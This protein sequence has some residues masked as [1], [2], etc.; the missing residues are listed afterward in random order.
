MDFELP[1]NDADAIE[2]TTKLAEK[3]Y[4]EIRET[5]GKLKQKMRDWE[6]LIEELVGDEKEQ[7]QVLLR[8]WCTEGAHEGDDMGLDKICTQA[9]S[10][11]TMLKSNVR[12]MRTRLES[13]TAD[14]QALAPRMPSREQ[15]NG[16]TEEELGFSH[17]VSADI[18]MGKLLKE[19]EQ[20]QKRVL[21]QLNSRTKQP[22]ESHPITSPS[23]NEEGRMKGGK[24]QGKLPP[25]VLPTFDGDPRQWIAFTQAFNSI[26]DTREIGDEGKF[27]Y[28]RGAL[29]GAALR[30]I[31]GLPGT[32]D[33]YRVAWELLR[34]RFG[35][36]VKRRDKLQID[37]DSLRRCPESASLDQLRRQL[38]RMDGIMRQL[39]VMGENINTPEIAGVFR[40]VFPLY[41]VEEVAKLMS[42]KREWS[43]KD[44]RNAIFSIL[45]AKEYAIEGAKAQAIIAAAITASV[46]KGSPMRRNETVKKMDQKKQKTCRLCRDSHYASMCP[47]YPNEIRKKERAKE[48][49]LCLRC[50]GSH[51]TEDCKRKLR[52]FFCK[53]DHIAAFCPNKEGRK[54]VELNLTTVT[55]V[56]TM[57]IPVTP[58]VGEE[59]VLLPVKDAIVTREVQG[60]PELTANIFLDGGAQASFITEAFARRLNATPVESLTLSISTVTQWGE[61]IT[62]PRYLLRIRR[63]DGSWT[64]VDVLGLEDL[65]KMLRAPVNVATGPTVATR[66]TEV[67]MLIG[68]D[69]YYKIVENPNVHESGFHIIKSAIGDILHGTGNV[70]TVAATQV[71]TQEQELNRLLEREWSLEGIGIH[72]D[73]LEK[74]DD[75]AI[76]QFQRSIQLMEGRYWARLPKKG[77]IS[78]LKDNYTLAL[79][80]LR[81]VLR[82]LQEKDP[83]SL[84]EYARIIAEQEEMGI[85][86]RVK[87]TSGEVVHYI[88]HHM[89]HGKKKRIVYDASAKTRKGDM[90]LNDLLLRG[91]LLLADLTGILLRFRACEIAT[92]ADIAKAFLMIALF[93]EDRDLL[94]FLFVKNIS[95]PPEGDNLIVYRFARLPF[96]LICAPFILNA[97][98]RHHLISYPDTIAAE[99]ADNVY[100]D[101]VVLNASSTIEAQEKCKEA[102]EIFKGAG[103]ELREFLSSDQEVNAGFADKGQ[104]L[105]TKFLGL[106]WNT[107]DDTLTIKSKD[108]NPAAWTKREVA[109]V[110]GEAYDPA[111]YISP[112]LLEAKRFRQKI[113]NLY[114]WSDKLS[115]DYLQEW[116]AI[117]TKIANKSFVIPRR[118]TTLPVSHVSELHVFCDASKI[119]YGTAVYAICIEGQTRTSALVFARSRIVPED[120]GKG[121]ITIPRLELT[122][123]T[124]GLSHLRF[125]AQELKVDLQNCTIWTDS[126]CVI[127]WIQSSRGEVLPKFVSNRILELHDAGIEIRHVGTEQNPADI[128]S[129]GSTFEELQDN[130]LW[131]KGP[132][133]LCLSE[134]NWPNKFRED[135]SKGIKTIQVATAICRGRLGQIQFVDL[136][137]FNSW[138]TAVR[139]CAWTLKVAL[140][141]LSG[142]EPKSPALQR[143]KQILE[144]GQRKGLTKSLVELAK[145][146][147][148]QREQK[149]LPPT[150][151]ERYNLDL[152]TDDQGT[153]RCKGRLGKAEL[154]EDTKHPVFIPRDSPLAELL[155]RDCHLVNLH[156][157][158]SQTVNELRRAVWIPRC[159]R[160][161]KGVISRCP[162]C[163]RAKARP[164][165]APPMAEL[166][167]ERVQKSG[168]F[169]HV[170]LDY[171]GPYTV[172]TDY[173]EKKVWVAIFVC[174]ATRAIHLEVVQGLSAANCLDIIRR[175]VAR[176]G[177]PQSFTSDNAPC[178]KVVGKT[179]NSAWQANQDHHWDKEDFEIM[180]YC[181][182]S[183]IR[184]RHIVELAPWQGGIWERAVSV[185]KKPLK[186]ALG[187]AIPHIEV[188][189]T[190]ICEIEA[191]VNCRPLLAVGA[192][193]SQVLRPI[194]FLMPGRLPGTPILQV[195]DDTSYGEETTAEELLNLWAITNK[196]LD[197]FWQAWLDEYLPNLRTQHRP[198]HTQP[199]STADR[200]PKVGEVVLIGEDEIPRAAWRL[201]TIKELETSSD[202]AVRAVKLGLQNGKTLRRAVNMIYPLE[203]E[204]HPG[205]QESNEIQNSPDGE[206]GG[207]SDDVE[208]AE[209]QSSL[210]GS[211]RYNFRPRSMSYTHF[212]IVL[213]LMAMSSANSPLLSCPEWSVGCHQG[214]IKATALMQSSMADTNT[215]TKLLEYLPDI[216]SLREGSKCD[217]QESQRLVHQIQ[218]HDG[219][220][221]FVRELTIDPLDSM[222]HIGEMRI[223]IKAWGTVRMMVHDY[224]HKAMTCLECGA[225]CTRGGVKL[226]TDGLVEAVE[227][228]ALDHC[229]R[230]R[231]PKEE[232][233]INLPVDVVS[234]PHKVQVT[235]WKKGE[236]VLK[237]VLNCPASAFCEQIV[238]WICLERV[239]NWEHCGSFYYAVI[240]AIG[241]MVMGVLVLKILRLMYRITLCIHRERPRRNRRISVARL[242]WLTILLEV[243][244]TIILILGRQG[245]QACAELASISAAE[246]NCH[247]EENGS[248][249][250]HFNDA[251]RVTVRPAGQLACLLL[252]DYNGIVTGTLLLEIR[253]IKLHCQKSTQFYSRRYRTETLAVRR[254]PTSGSCRADKCSKT[255]PGEAIPELQNVNDHP[256]FSQCTDGGEWL[257]NGCALPT[258]SCIFY[259]VFARAV[260][261]DVIEVFNCPSWRAVVEVNA[262]LRLGNSQVT[263]LLELRSGE[264]GP[265]TDHIRFMAI[266]IIIPPTPSLHDAFASDGH[267]MTTLTDEDIRKTA[268][269]CPS[270]EDAEKFNLRCLFMPQCHC[271]AAGDGVNCACPK[272]DELEYALE[273]CRLPITIQ[274]LWLEPDTDGPVAR[275]SDGSVELEINFRDL[276]ASTINDRARCSATAPTIEGCYACR[277]G[278]VVTINCHSSFG[279]IMAEL[280]CPKG[281]LM[282][283][284]CTPDTSTTQTLIQLSE[285]E[286]D[287]ECILTCPASSEKIRLTAVLVPPAIRADHFLSVNVQHPLAVTGFLSWIG[288]IGIFLAWQCR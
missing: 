122:A 104:P 240:I 267:V 6:D 100:A 249:S 39:E 109:A 47:R 16:A 245:A 134:D 18:S 156:A 253:T 87:D 238:C 146:L 129:R 60:G 1:G 263:E 235:A 97:T 2:T 268:L 252:K 186:T 92:T 112:T 59:E 149:N 17:E 248:I 77:D 163:A 80:R 215:A 279:D 69:Q 244:V 85:I 261:E 29:T 225:H 56:V 283:I 221:H 7:Q 165:K 198:D 24:P 102:I 194:D 108:R 223:P 71:R 284:R 183:G 48:L 103:M 27:T 174:L 127:G 277:T 21:E 110:V 180:D 58:R 288:L 202:G 201:A 90:A 28:L 54:T 224:A 144:G 70:Y 11:I 126:S 96:G 211:S 257:A 55:E 67:D 218:L 237:K 227:I 37:L 52:C 93:D 3:K 281:I 81:S 4:Y 230:T 88:P 243:V 189:T 62:A 275:L 79:G 207:A 187:R 36:T 101:N 139:V 38:E 161:T 140:K 33:C 31:E 23:R 10:A 273:K 255:D 137:R 105:I 168:P 228:C 95:L 260:D 280:K 192:D 208:N 26:V 176:R 147:I 84:Q 178:F 236:T 269:R 25:L 265:L 153:L 132:E 30:T 111:G 232:E 206:K 152:Q 136:I 53:A 162:G 82:N 166:P 89:V 210:R 251:M 193:T 216:C 270:R 83:E 19:F 226:D 57:S 20:F 32:D 195:E 125:A 73:P 45:E 142:K 164:F 167:P 266:N 231:K 74:D 44:T 13:L 40:R 209:K 51:K 258:P 15:G 106:T 61:V 46:E 274:S 229:E 114:D 286:F 169:N 22:N 203:I 12:G 158:A 14:R 213:A 65:T 145:S 76:D 68:G 285:P 276:H 107:I 154:P 271:Q 254:C 234:A 170:G 259:R 148:I 172:K 184:W 113:H 143:A 182:N 43:V 121:E 99:I 264:S 123:V 9:E 86:E 173:K 205:E 75:L 185:V 133:W 278:A 239:W 220:L 94:R 171:F 138:R 262:T 242:R 98:I 42:H 141:M 63:L 246:Q 190:L 116:R 241:A 160:K 175:F 287:E 157:G 41:I 115:E 214:P 181:E 222:L 282:A 66:W 196:R 204:P 200:A 34:E 72:D 199:R 119:A 177:R 233:T 179:I 250:C 120:K 131:F 91:P 124:M 217:P 128:S 135:S 219:S 64:T 50:L 118:I 197:K 212:F 5:L 188:L 130:Q 78:K 151:E 272:G 159:L 247:R 117:M 256:G 150:K 8:K 191:V 155:I 49:G 35:S